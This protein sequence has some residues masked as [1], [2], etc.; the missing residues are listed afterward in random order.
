MIEL[1]GTRRPRDPVTAAWNFETIL[2]DATILTGIKLEHVNGTVQSRGKWDGRNI[3][4]RGHID[5]DSVYVWNHQ[6]AKVHGPFKLDNQELTVGAEQAFIPL[7]A[8]AREADSERGPRDR[9]CR[10][11]DIFPR[12][13]SASRRAED[14]LPRQNGHAERQ[15]G[16]I[17]PASRIRRRPRFT[18]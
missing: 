6:F 5:L 8:G 12:R 7:A 16:R 3:K 17:R 11:G 18:G 1:R 2:S 9:P 13:Q 14:D 4:M 15:L 10:R